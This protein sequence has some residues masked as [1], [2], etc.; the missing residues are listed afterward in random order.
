MRKI[1]TRLCG[2]RVLLLVVS[3]VLSVALLEISATAV[4]YHYFGTTPSAEARA[5]FSP[6]LNPEAI[7]STPGDDTFPI[8]VQ[9]KV[10]HPYFGFVSEIGNSHGFIGPEPFTMKTDDEVVVAITGG[11]VAFHF[12]LLQRHSTLLRDAFPNKKVK[13]FALAIPGYKQP[14]QL[15]AFTYMLMRNVKFDVLIN[16]DGF[17]EVALPHSENLPKNVHPSYPRLWYFHSQKTLDQGSVL[18]A[19]R[20][21][22]KKEQQQHVRQLLRRGILS[23]SAFFTTLA[24]TFDNRYQIELDKMQSDLGNSLAASRKESK[25]L[26][27]SFSYET[28]QEKWNDIVSIWKNSSLH[29]HQLAQANG[30]TYLHLLQP[31]QWHKNS[32]SFS[33]QERA[34]WADEYPVEY[35]KAVEASYSLL[36]A[37]GKNLAALGVPFADLSMAFADEKRTLYYDS[38]CHFNEHGH[39][40][41]AK[42][43]VKMI[44]RYYR[45]D[46]GSNRQDR[47][48]EN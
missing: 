24:E 28:E 47:S 23:R 30:I 42:R 46:G 48:S 31:N 4:R 19:G 45:K 17:N 3:S 27:P 9:K 37:E 32:K 12:A 21:L 38:C 33:Q 36:I 44:D 13:F 35:R 29:M 15:L 11:S 16:L 18:Q 1:V 26:G 43:V 5:R 14:Q 39:E 10:L 8:P 34:L 22:H 40:I 2:S 41:I 7:L 20:I 25:I 6:E